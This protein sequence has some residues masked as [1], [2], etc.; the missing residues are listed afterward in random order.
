MRVLW[1]TEVQPSAVREHL[2]LPRRPGPQAWVDGLA[3]ALRDRTELDLAIAS[4][5][6]E[7]YASFS[8]ERIHYVNV[9]LEMTTSRLR[10]I[11]RAWRHQLTPTAVLASARALVMEMRPDI[12]HVHG[13]EGGFGLLAGAVPQVPCVISLQGILHAYERLYFAGRTPRDVAD[14]VLSKEFLKGRGVVHRYLLLR[15]QAVREEEIMRGARWFMGRTDWDRA[16][17][18]ACNP[19]AEYR[20]CDEI[21]RSP[22]YGGDWSLRSHGGLRLYSTSSA[23][24]G[25]GTECLIQAAAILQRRGLAGLRV[26]VA[27]VQEDSE[28]DKLYRRSARRLGVDGHIEWLGRLGAEEIVTELET[29]DV[30]VYPSHVD[31]SPNALVEAML[32]GAPIVA[33]HV[34]GTPTLLKHGV[35]GLLVSRGDPH[36]LAAAV[37]RLLEN[38]ME[39][40]ALGAAARRSAQ[41]RND[42]DQIAARTIAIYEEIVARS[43]PGEPHRD[44]LATR[45]R[46]GESH[47]EDVSSG[48]VS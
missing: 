13:T 25:K 39:A 20:H 22:F 27:G 24:M 34:G 21:M 43:R 7:P 8:R 1:F 38:R 18:E 40:A 11:A 30:F 10:R 23:L 46:D 31:N 48:G 36:A 42:P 44:L 2:G 47:H 28:L 6:V 41:A 19:L 16:M 12:V 45:T 4:P 32:C 29:A 5:G 33:T 15:R 3:G 9:P 17:L 37:Q 26:R 14:L 35:E